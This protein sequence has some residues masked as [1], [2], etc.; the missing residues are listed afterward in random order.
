VPLDFASAPFAALPLDE[1]HLPRNGKI[2]VAVSGGADSMALLLALCGAEYSCLAAHV[3][4]NTRG[5]ESDG[6]E[7]FVRQSCAKLKIPFL[8][9]KL[10]LPPNA[11]ENAMRKARYTALLD[12]SRQYSCAVIATGHTANDN[13][14]TILLNWLRGA[15]VSGLAGI[16]PMREL[17]AGVLLARPLLGATRTQICD[18]LIARRQSWREDS[19]N[20]SARYLRNRVRAELLPVLSEMGFD[21]NRLAL[22]TLRAAQIWRDDLKVLE[23]AAGAALNDCALRE[24]ENMLILDGKKFCA[25]PIALQ[26]RVLRLGAKKL[27]HPAREIGAARVEEVRLHVAENRRR[28][29]WFWSQSLRVEWTGDKSGNR[30]RIRCV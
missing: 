18:F 20:Q 13:L 28:A 14:E 24:D 4:H 25:L 7:D 21:E 5:E 17:A 11:N 15:S 12:W 19:S 8:T 6:D 1:S 22:Q 3:N 26:R 10:D 29:V 9:T 16:P 30:I 2:L 23:A 27:E